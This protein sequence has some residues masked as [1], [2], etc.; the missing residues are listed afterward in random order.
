MESFISGFAVTVLLVGG[1][2]EKGRRPSAVLVAMTAATNERVALLAGAKIAVHEKVNKRTKTNCREHMCITLAQRPTLEGSEGALTKNKGPDWEVDSRG[3]IIINSDGER[4]R[5][6]Q[7]RR[8]QGL[9]SD[10]GGIVA[11]TGPRRL[12]LLL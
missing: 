4:V 9:L 5:S 10:K 7:D 12:H 2:F 1:N 3:I 11:L 8:S 6:V